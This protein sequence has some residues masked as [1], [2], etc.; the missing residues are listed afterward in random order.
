[1][2]NNPKESSPS[3]KARHRLSIRTCSLR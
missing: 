2:G 3:E 1:M